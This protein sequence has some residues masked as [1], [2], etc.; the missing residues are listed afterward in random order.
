EYWGKTIPE[1]QGKYIFGDVV[2]GRLFYIEVDDIQLESQTTIREL[3]F[4]IDGRPTSFG[5]MFDNKKVDI[6]FGRDHQG[7]L[8]VSTKADGKIYRVTS[9]GIKSPTG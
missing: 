9:A 7:E 5:E 3:H 1:L 4:S 2:R 8:W 6:R